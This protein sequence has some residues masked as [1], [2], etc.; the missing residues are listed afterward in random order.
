M[1]TEKSKVVVF[2]I[3]TFGKKL[4]ETLHEKW[5]V[6]AIDINEEK[7][8]SI[9]HLPNVETIQGDASSILLWKKLNFDSTN[10]IVITVKDP[11]VSFE[12]CRI[13]RDILNIKDIPITIYLYNETKEELF[14]QCENINL[15][16]PTSLVVGATVSL[17][18]KNYKIATNIGLGKGEIIEV[19]ILARSHLVDRK[20]KYI[21]SNKWRVAAIYRDNKLILPSGNQRLKIGDSVVLVGEPKVLENL[22]NIFTKGIPQFPLQ[23]GNTITGVY[24]KRFSQEIKELAYFTQFLKVSRIDILLYGEETILDKEKRFLES[25]F[26]KPVEISRQIKSLVEAVKLAPE[27]TAFSGI[28]AKNLSFFEKLQIKSVF[29]NSKLPFLLLRD[30]YPYDEIVVILN[31]PEPAYTLEIGVEI[32]RILKSKLRAI[33]VAMPK[34]LRSEEEEEELE[35]VQNIVKDFENIY[36]FSMNF[37]LL[38]GNPVKESLKVLK[39]I[40]KA[41]VVISY[42]KQKISIFE[43]HVQYLIAK[44]SDKSCFLIPIEEENE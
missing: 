21:K 23:F 38:E 28:P 3:G 27:G 32:A 34:E 4:V 7:L 29:E 17:I 19:K 16:R 31:S 5:H 43:P 20:L 36:K 39:E 44:K 30:S 15:I 2:G 26:N 25:I 9:K 37:T 18:E 24:S 10:H 33:Y 12:A 8:N 11:D 6:I 42:K 35:D 40:P 1:E 13:A 41:L 22:A 14:N